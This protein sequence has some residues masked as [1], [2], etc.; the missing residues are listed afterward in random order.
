ML[1]HIQATARAAAGCL[2][3]KHCSNAASTGPHPA[4]LAAERQLCT[5][6]AIM[7]TA[8]A[9]MPPQPSCKSTGSGP[10]QQHSSYCSH[11]TT[12]VHHPPQESSQQLPPLIGKQHACI[13]CRT[14]LSGALLIGHADSPV[15]GPSVFKKTLLISRH[16]YVT[17]K[18][19]C[20]LHWPIFSK[21]IQASYLHTNRKS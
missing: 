5:N 15:P 4:L 19:Q 14:T 2:C 18:T 16:D 11:S 7:H 21:P 13:A 10:Q 6:N 12:H 1:L 9:T 20:N 3:S 17:Q 8:T